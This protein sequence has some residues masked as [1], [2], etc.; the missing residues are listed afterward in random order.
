M[1]LFVIVNVCMFSSLEIL[2]IEMGFSL[3]F[4]FRILV[5]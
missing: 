5:V 3:H 1:S 4:F 2:P